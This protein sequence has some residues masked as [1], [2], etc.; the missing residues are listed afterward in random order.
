[1]SLEKVYILN[2]PE[3]AIWG[4]DVTQMSNL[5]R[6]YKHCNSYKIHGHCS[7]PSTLQYVEVYSEERQ[8]NNGQEN[9][10]TKE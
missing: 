10:E 4:L 5:T 3:A 2:K 8:H 6:I 1:M 9:P 7:S